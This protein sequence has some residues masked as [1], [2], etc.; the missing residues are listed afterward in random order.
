[1]DAGQHVL[2]LRFRGRRSSDA[3]PFAEL[4]WVRI[5]TPDELERT[6]RDRIERPASMAA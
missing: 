1:M 5:G 4:D 3:E 2:Q 6:R